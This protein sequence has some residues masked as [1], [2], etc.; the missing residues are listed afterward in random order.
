MKLE[1]SNACSKLHSIYHLT[2]LTVKNEQ[3][4]QLNR[5]GRSHSR[6]PLTCASSRAQQ[7]EERLLF[8]PGK[9]SGKESHRHFVCTDFPA[10]FALYKSSLLPLP[11]RDLHMALEP[12]IAILCWSQPI[13]KKLKNKTISAGE[14]SGNLLISGQ[15]D[16][17]CASQLPLHF[18]HT[19]SAVC[20]R[21]C[22][23]P[24]FPIVAQSDESKS[25]EERGRISRAGNSWTE[26]CVWISIGF[27]FFW[28]TDIWVLILV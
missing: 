20:L 5:L 14:I 15:P 12:Q 3:K 18:P 23:L 25:Q 16:L 7:E 8:F 11:C 17:P 6:V 19:R 27:S 2:C 21:T 13:F 1:K 22:S 26:L 10:S 24:V 28:C 4:P 9:H